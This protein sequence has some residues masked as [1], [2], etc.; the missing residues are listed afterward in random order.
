MLPSS[1]KIALNIST[2]PKSYLSV[3]KKLIQILDAECAI[4]KGKSIFSQRANIPLT[5]CHEILQSFLGDMSLQVVFDWLTDSINSDLKQKQYYNTLQ[6]VTL[7]NVEC[8][9]ISHLCLY[10]ILL[11]AKP[12]GNTLDFSSHKTHATHV[13][14]KFG[15]Q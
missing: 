5:L 6:H 11:H 13:A 1:F 4:T 8:R 15:S 9:D 7:C 3:R 14:R 10:N 2:S 12:F